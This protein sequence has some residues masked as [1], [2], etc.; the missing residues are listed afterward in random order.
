MG[1]MNVYQGLR[2]TLHIDL[3]NIWVPRLTKTKSKPECSRFK[4][5]QNKMYLPLLCAANSQNTT[6]RVDS[7]YYFNVSK[8]PRR[9]D[10]TLVSTSSKSPI[11]GLVKNL[12]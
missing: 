2:S 3:D 6:R 4:A 7:K 1:V 12:H 8:S 11:F 5:F 9:I 10:S